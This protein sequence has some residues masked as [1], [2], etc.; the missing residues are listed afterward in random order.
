MVYRQTDLK[1]KLFSEDCWVF[2]G[3]GIEV[4]MTGEYIKT[5]FKN[6][7]KDILKNDAM[8]EIKLSNE[9]DE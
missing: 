1:L 4:K 6:S 7:E 9:I 5:H 2:N 8:Y 3:D